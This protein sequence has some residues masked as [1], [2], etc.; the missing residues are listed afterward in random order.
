MIDAP[1][2]F[3]GGG[4]S[5]GGTPGFCGSAKANFF[6]STEVTCTFFNSVA[7]CSTPGLSGTEVSDEKLLIIPITAAVNT[8]VNI[9]PNLSAEANH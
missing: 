4:F 5:M 3:S 6:S 1:A 2:G 8:I 7:C 9:I